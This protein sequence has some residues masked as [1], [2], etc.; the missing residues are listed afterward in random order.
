MKTIIIK[1]LKELFFNV[2]YSIPT[3]FVVAFILWLVRDAIFQCD[4]GYMLYVK[5]VFITCMILCLVEFIFSTVSCKKRAEKIAQ[6]WQM[7]IEDIIEGLYYFKIGG[8]SGTLSSK[9]NFQIQLNIKRRIKNNSA[10]DL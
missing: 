2:L 6:K 4:F 7:S 5:Y 8:E 3:A 10:K 1:N 9:D